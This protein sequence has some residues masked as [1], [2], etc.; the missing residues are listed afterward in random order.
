MA[1]MINDDCTSC[2]ACRDEC[3]SQA[4]SEGDMTYVIAP[5]R[6]TEWARMPNMT[7]GAPGWCSRGMLL[8]GSNCA[9]GRCL[10]ALTNSLDGNPKNWFKNRPRMGRNSR[11][12]G[13]LEIRPDGR[14]PPSLSDSS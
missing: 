10:V 8:Q 7:A 6:C 12:K 3:P 11:T 5:D 9:L 13:G 2:D 14:W 1:L 4:I